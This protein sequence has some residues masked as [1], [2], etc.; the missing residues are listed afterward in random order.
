MKV[1]IGALL[2]EGGAEMLVENLSKQ[3][4]E[5]LELAEAEQ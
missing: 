5:R 1:S 3:L 4:D 2:H